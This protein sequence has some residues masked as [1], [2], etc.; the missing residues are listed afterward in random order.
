MGWGRTLLLGDIGNRLDIGDTENEISRLK[1]VVDGAYRK[2]MSQDNK[3]NM[4]IRENA[5]LKL[6][7]A[8]ITR[9]LISKGMI[10]NEELESMVQAIDVSDGKADGKF[11][12]SI[13]FTNE[14]INQ[15]KEE[16]PKDQKCNSNQ[17]FYPRLKRLTR[18][19]WEAAGLES[20]VLDQ[21]PSKGPESAEFLKTQIN[22]IEI[23]PD[24]I[25]QAF[26]KLIGK[27][28]QHQDQPKAKAS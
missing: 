14:E 6:Y 20:D 26:D 10:S 2:D 27:N 13:V 24:S 5:E 4:L 17:K 15:L 22:S 25:K 1:R 12:G 7:L 11:D 28:E 23:I 19:K 16:I 8:S 18:E 9:L 3:I 21:I